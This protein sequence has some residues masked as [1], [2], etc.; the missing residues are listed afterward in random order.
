MENKIIV[1][2]VDGT[3]LPSNGELDQE[4]VK[5]LNELEKNNLIV[6]AT[7]RSYHELIKIRQTLN[8]KSPII[9]Q[10]GAA[11]IF[12]DRK[13]DVVLA[14]RKSI[15]DDLFSFAK[16]IIISAYYTNDNTIYIQNKLDKLAFLYKITE[17]SNV[18]CG[19]F[20][21]LDL[22]NPNSIYLV[23]DNNKK[24][25]FF[26][27]ITNLYS[28]EIKYYEFGH[29]LKHSIVILSLKNTD[30]AYA[31][32]EL[33]MILKK[34]LYDVIV[35]GDGPF[36]K[37]MLS[38]DCHTVAMANADDEIKKVAKHITEFNN[39][40]QGVMKYLKSIDN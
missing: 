2:D 30:K 15:I 24:E 12:Q 10:N 7:G 18:I 16:D 28:N 37:T 13:N 25:L 35:F 23:L 33:L 21:T 17:S 6:L 29:D 11:L 31:I 26:D 1:L 4:T 39:N 34:D 19:D 8:L 36:D 22:K 32:L 14:I 40:N 38:L 27:R 5:Y 9:T 3:L 20:T